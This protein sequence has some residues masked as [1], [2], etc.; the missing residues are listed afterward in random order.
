MLEV[1]N[2]SVAYGGLRAL[3]NVSLTVREGQF[4]TVVGPNGAGKSTLISIL[5]GVYPQSSGSV[6]LAGEEVTFTSVAD[7]KAKGVA[8]VF[9]EFSLVPTLS[10]AKNIFLGSEPMIGPFIDRGK[11]EIHFFALPSPPPGQAKSEESAKRQ[12]LWPPQ[13]WTS[14]P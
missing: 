11:M 12:Q 2:L 6:K 5:S 9:Q 3:T 10:V 13:L 1:S 7:A 8:A 14:T 4:V